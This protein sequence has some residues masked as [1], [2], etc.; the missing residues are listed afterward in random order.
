MSIEPDVLCDKNARDMVDSANQFE[1]RRAFL[2]KYTPS[3]CTENRCNANRIRSTNKHCMSRN[4]ELERIKHILSG[5]DL[6]T[7]SRHR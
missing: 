1:Y 2:N 7:K 3:S 6:K 4:S 5:K